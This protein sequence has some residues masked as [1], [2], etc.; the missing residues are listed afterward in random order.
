[1]LHIY[2]TIYVAR[3]TQKSIIIGKQG[4]AIKA[5]GKAAR[6]KLEAFFQTRIFLELHVKVRE[7]WRDDEKTLRHF[8]YQ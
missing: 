6:E 7:N 1:M 5:L 2:A 3:K 8:G 4:S